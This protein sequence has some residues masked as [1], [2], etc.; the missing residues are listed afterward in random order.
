M[1]TEKQR[2]ANLLV[3]VQHEFLDRDV[4]LSLADVQ[5][6]A[7]SD[8]ATCQAVLD[9]LVDAGVLVSLGNRYFRASLLP[10]LA[11]LPPA[12]GTLAA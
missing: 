1:T 6:L 7:G 11:P 8:A 3:R 4:A 2:V 5:Q 10:R 9:L 12:A